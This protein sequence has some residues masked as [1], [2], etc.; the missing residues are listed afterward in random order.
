MFSKILIANR[1]EIAVRIIRACRE[2]GI[3]T[4]AIYSQADKDA[5][6]VSLA[7][8]AYCVGPAQVGDS[9]LNMLSILTI[10]VNSGAQAI[11]P[12]YGLLSEN[13]KFA[14][15]CEECNIAFI[16]PSSQMISDLG[17]KDK[18]RKTMKAAGVPV[19]P[20][21]D[22][23]EDEN[24]AMKAAGEIGYPILI[25]ARSGGGGRGI[26]LVEKEEDFLNSFRSASSEAA[27]A[28]GDSGCY[29]EKFLKP[30][31]HIEMQ[32]LCDKHGNVLCLGER[33]CSV[34][35]KN[36]KLIEES[37]SPSLTPEIRKEMMDAAIKAAKAVNYNSVG[38]VEFLLDKD[39]N[40]YFMEMNTR[41]Q[42][43]HGVTEMVTGLD[44]V[45]WQIRVAAGT[46]LN[47]TQDQV[48][49]H[50]HAIECRINAE[51]PDKNFRPSCGKITQLHIPGGSFVRF[52][53]AIYQDYTIPPF[54]DSMVGK[55]IVQG[56]SREL[57]IRK[58]KM[59]LSELS[60]SGIDHN[61]ELQIEI[62][63]DKEFIDGSYTTDFIADFEERRKKK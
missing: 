62:L 9:Y 42:V 20:G 38:T 3:S 30:V 45:Q 54:Y 40:F 6:H 63:S 41:L 24:E 26:R 5:L 2:M 47:K 22:V 8:E 46:K 23:I 59:A 39:K 25:K 33:E 4:V 32:L 55:I 37:P 58:M 18:A 56:R 1:G 27:S 51:N 44:L 49:F 10:A 16:G 60:I 15:L 48:F 43:E 19:T 11:H 52:D 53:T 36:Q 35:R 14:S 17:D 61:R 31:K 34:Q 13:A 29:I 50:G 57:A 12:G 28:F 7:D 21:T